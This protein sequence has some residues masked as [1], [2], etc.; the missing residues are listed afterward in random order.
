MIYIGSK[1]YK[2]NEDELEVIR[3]TKFKN[4]NTIC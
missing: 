1:Y 3:V 2:Y 4:E